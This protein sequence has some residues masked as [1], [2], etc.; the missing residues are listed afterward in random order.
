M[1]RAPNLHCYRSVTP[2]ATSLALQLRDP[3]LDE[4]DHLRLEVHAIEAID[5]LHSRRTRHVHLGEVIADDVEADEVEPV[6]LQPR[7]QHAA[8]LSIAR[9]DRRLDGIAA[10]VDVPAMLIVTWHAK[11][12]TDR[13]AIEH[14]QPLVAVAHLRN[15]ALRHNRLGFEARD[16]F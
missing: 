4:I 12:P 13:L 7:P 8:D 16:G 1:R 11:S 6:V 14:D 2:H 10:D 9:C 3:R 15:V 5:L